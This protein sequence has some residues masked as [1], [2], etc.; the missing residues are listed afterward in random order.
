MEP[1]VSSNE[2][3]ECPSL[4]LKRALQEIRK[5]E[6]PEVPNP[7]GCRKRASVALILR[8]HPAA[9]QR[10]KHPEDHSSAHDLDLS[11]RLDRFFAQPWVQQGDPEVLLIKRAARHGDRWTSHVALPG[12]K[13]DSSDGSDRDTSIRET[14]EETG[15]DLEQEHCL[16]IGNL[17]QRTI[18]TAWGNDPLMVLCPFVYLQTRHDLPPLALQPSEIHSAH[19]VSLRSLLLPSLRRSVRCNASERLAR[20]RTPILRIVLRAL[21]GRLVFSAVKLKP[22][23]SLYSNPLLNVSSDKPKSPSITTTLTRLFTQN[24]SDPD[25]KPMLLWGLTLGIMADLLELLDRPATTKLWSWPTF[26]PW[27]IRIVIWLLNHNFRAQ[28]IREIRQLRSPDGGESEDVQIGGMDDTTYTTSVKRK[29]GGSEA[30][31]AGMKLLGD[32]MQRLRNAVIV[33]LA[34][35]VGFGAALASYLF[36]KYRRRL[37]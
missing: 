25:D 26:S 22:T 14:M 6:C 5:H 17:P 32:Y 3:T 28:K 37:K 21:V 35:R 1:A 23:E 12:G 36:R 9:S 20:H 33:A 13:R 19:W 31:V 8:I 10:P 27:D 16:Y 18:T 29:T 4:R 7:P 34:L 11:T 15:V 30:G 24:Q 2:K